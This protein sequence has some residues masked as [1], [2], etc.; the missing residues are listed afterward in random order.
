MVKWSSLFIMI[1]DD[2]K[3]INSGIF[4]K[5]L[6]FENSQMHREPYTLFAI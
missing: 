1:S 6:M 3:L 4:E 2:F 5:S